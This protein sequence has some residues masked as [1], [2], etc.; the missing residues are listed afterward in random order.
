[1][2]CLLGALAGHDRRKL[3]VLPQGKNCRFRICRGDRIAAVSG[4][5]NGVGI[6]A[7]PVAGAMVL[8][9]TEPRLLDELKQ[10]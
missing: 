8:D 9:Q 2:F 4:F 1:L 5:L 7:E 6:I 3:G 10:A